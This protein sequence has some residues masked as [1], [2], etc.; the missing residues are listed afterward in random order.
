VQPERLHQW[1]IPE[2]P[3]DIE[4]ATFQLLAQYLN[5]LRYRVHPS[6]KGDYLLF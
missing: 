4:A 3:L 2:T 6:P 5:I 1:K